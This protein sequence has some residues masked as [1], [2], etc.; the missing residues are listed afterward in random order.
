MV[1]KT[2]KTVSL[3]LNASQQKIT[4]WFHGI[5]TLITRR[6]ALTEYDKKKAQLLPKLVEAHNKGVTF[7]ELEETTGIPYQTIAHWVRK[8]QKK[9]VPNPSQ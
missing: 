9:N 2:I 4:E 8:E 1:S 6:E 7:R 5:D 3:L